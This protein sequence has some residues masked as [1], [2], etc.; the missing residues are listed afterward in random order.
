MNRAARL[1]AVL[2]ATLVVVAGLAFT[3]IY[4]TTFPPT[5]TA[6]ATPADTVVLQT[7]GAIGYGNHPTWVSY[8][9]QEN[10]QWIHST[11][12]TV[13]ANADIHFKIYQYDSGSPLRNPF[14]NQVAG[15]KDGTILLNG[16]PARIINDQTDGGIGHTFAIPALGVYVPMPGVSSTSTNTC[17]TP[18][19]CATTFDHNTVEF[20]IHTGPA[21]TYSWQCFVPCGLGFLIGNGGPMSTLGYMG[22][23][24]KVV[25]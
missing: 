14:M 2:A 15:T 10:G 19:P 16:Q 18:A 6:A 9:A 21:G 11:M 17:S 12:L 23:F 22:G 20:T 7:V 5:V 4:L 8:L 13:P 25:A 3:W 24:L 1:L